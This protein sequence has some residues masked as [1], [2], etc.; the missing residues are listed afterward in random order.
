MQAGA[1]S[2]EPCGT[3]VSASDHKTAASYDSS[4]DVNQADVFIAARRKETE[5]AG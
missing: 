5:R 1:G 4:L 2:R 3:L